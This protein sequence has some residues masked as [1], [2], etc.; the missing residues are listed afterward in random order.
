[1]VASTLVGDDISIRFYTQE[2][3]DDEERGPKLDKKE[4]FRDRETIR[5][6]KICLET[7]TEPQERE[8]KRER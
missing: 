4:R 2:E 5:E 6:G 1:M 3:E 7:E 8:I